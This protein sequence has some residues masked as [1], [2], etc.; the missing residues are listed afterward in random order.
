MFICK[1]CKK[2]IS[3]KDAICPACQCVQASSS[4]M[5]V[6]PVLVYKLNSTSLQEC[7]NYLES[8]S[9]FKE[10]ILSS[11]PGVKKE[12]SEGILSHNQI[13]SGCRRSIILNELM[14]LE[15]LINT[16]Y[17]TFLK[18]DFRNENTLGNILRINTDLRLKSLHIYCDCFDKAAITEKDREIK[19]FLYLLNLRNNLFH[20]NI[21][22]KMKLK[23]SSND[24]DKN[25]KVFINN[26]L[27]RDEMNKDFS[28]DI[29]FS[30]AGISSS[31]V[32]KVKLIIE[33]IV[34]KIFRRMKSD[35]SFS[36]F[37]CVHSM[38]FSS[39]ELDNGR[40]FPAALTTVEDEAVIESLE[41]K[42]NSLIENCD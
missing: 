10:N 17:H 32:E 2:K 21:T 36:F 15:A 12:F 37:I 30:A 23:R 41:N 31:D 24:L 20:S 9:E 35:V 26:Y 16:I 4:D 13:I 34:G 27:S 28:S 18:K 14:R 39:L 7:C 33:K 19:S 5:I 22:K 6:N 1:K 29:F 11:F 8:D 40:H 3:E 42:F 25:F 38:I